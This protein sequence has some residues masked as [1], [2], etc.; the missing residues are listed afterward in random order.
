MLRWWSPGA[1]DEGREREEVVG[2]KCDIIVI[3]FRYYDIIV[4]L[5]DSCD[6]EAMFEGG[7]PAA[8]IFAND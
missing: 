7:Q 8:C 5:L 6:D 2:R 4:R 1:W 3:L